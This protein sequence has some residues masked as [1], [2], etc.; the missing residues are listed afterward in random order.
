MSK[1]GIIAPTTLVQFFKS[2]GVETIESDSDRSSAVAI[3]NAV[4]AAPGGIAAFPILV[5]GDVDFSGANAWLRAMTT[6][7]G[8][9]IVVLGGDAEKFATAGNVVHIP[10]PASMQEVF[11]NLEGLAGIAA[12]DRFANI[13]IQA[14]FGI[15]DLASG[16]P[17]AP[18]AAPVEEELPSDLF[19]T[20]PAPSAP[21]ADAPSWAQAATPAQQPVAQPSPEPVAPVTPAAPVADAPAWAQAAAP[22]APAPVAPVAAE[23]VYTPEPAAPAAEPVQVAEPAPAPLPHD[24]Y[25]ASPVDVVEEE[26]AAF[27]P[28]ETPAP[29]QEAAPVYTPE[30][31]YTP[32]PVQEA[33]PVFT[34]E[35]AAVPA[36]V[37]EAAP[38]T[39]AAPAERPLTRRELAA[40]A[41]AEA[42]ANAPAEAAPVE[43]TPQAPAWASA[44]AAPVEEAPQAPAWASAPVEAAPEILTPPAEAAKPVTTSMPFSTAPAELERP[45]P[46]PMGGPRQIRVFNPDLGTMTPAEET[47]AAPEPAPFAPEPVAETPAYEA[48]PVTPAQPMPAVDAPPV[49]EPV[50]VPGWATAPAPQPETAPQYDAP[51]AQP[52]YEAPAPQY[53][54]PQYAQ[55]SAPAPAY[56]EPPAYTAPRLEP[57][58]E[59][60]SGPRGKI[61]ASF[62]AK[63]GVT[64]TTS[65]LV[66][67]DKAAK[68]GLR[69]TVI[70]MDKGQDNVG[71]YLRLRSASLPTIF[72]AAASGNPAAALVTPPQ[73]ARHRADASGNL[74]FAVVFGPGN[75]HA[76]NHA[77]LTSQ[78]YRDVI[79]FAAANSDLVILDN[80]ILKAERSSSRLFYDV[81]LPLL[82]QEAYGLGIIDQSRPGLEDLEARLKELQ[83]DGLTR[84]RMLIMA[85]NTTNFNDVQA[86]SLTKRFRTFGDFVGATSR[87]DAFKA[88]LNIGRIPS[89]SPAVSA[90]MDAILLRVTGNPAFAPQEKKKKR[91]GLF[92]R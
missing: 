19:P 21:V 66:L 26:S 11:Q 44:P 38:F 84:D 86:D 47:P 89:D 17:S 20:T 33:A 5:H 45:E 7:R 3:T 32:A 52:V 8:Y 60:P 81:V 1:L 54:A 70:D 79:D 22:V 48:A 12:N 31:V 56:T 64:K 43:E 10:L 50:A 46:A 71:S 24:F 78:V 77:S 29:V 30:P 2:L 51:A 57:V 67:A 53:E 13:Q 34:P 49:G 82:K 83:R 9:R 63:G 88:Q 73:Y 6:T 35:P 62:A 40:R 25:T 37:Q 91:R 36:P 90:T 4:S 65:A 39:P 69:T 92:G 16:A 14:D 61:L 23:P 87:D 75:A 74:D 76:S 72:D 15:V 27:V 59:T 80:Q 58:A 85:A 68:A 42:A 28:D 55:P 41:A 18:A